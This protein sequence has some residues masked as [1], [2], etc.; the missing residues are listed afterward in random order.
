ME[1]TEVR[2]FLR[3]SPDKKLKAY[4]TVTFD[5]SFVVRDI[6]VIEGNKGL[7]VAMP[8][9][10]LRNSCPKCGHRN[11]INSKY[12]NKC[13]AQLEVSERR[14]PTPQD[15]EN[16]HRDIAHPIKQEFRNY[17][18]Q[19]VLDAYQAEMSKEGGSK[20]AFAETGGTADAANI[21]SEDIKPEEQKPEEVA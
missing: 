18:Q 21:N 13:G 12:C 3:E 8:S 17:L 2:M 11:V 20:S 7:F 9:R 19:K 10:R 1:I 4:A 5:D 15:R 16:E 6:K 14:E